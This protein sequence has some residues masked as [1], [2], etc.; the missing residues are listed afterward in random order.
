MIIACGPD[1]RINLIDSLNTPRRRN[2]HDQLLGVIKSLPSKD[3]D[4]RYRSN[5][6][7]SW[8]VAISAQSQI[9]KK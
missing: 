1:E 9:W 4:P 3:N 2:N 5:P 8:D 6:P 7:Q